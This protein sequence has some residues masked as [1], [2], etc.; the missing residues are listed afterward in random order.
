MLLHDLIL[1]RADTDGV[2]PALKKGDATI[3]YASACDGIRRVAAG[4]ANAGLR[5]GE[6]VAV[7]LN[8]R[9]EAVLSYFGATC[10]GGV[11]V[12]VNPSLKPAQVAHILRDCD[13][14]SLVTTS[15]QAAGLSEVLAGC[16]KLRD[17]ILLDETAP[18]PSLPPHVQALSWEALI[19]AA[20]GEPVR[21]IDTDMAAILYTSGSTG[22]PKGVVL[23]HR[24]LIV[25]GQSVSQYLANGP[26]D[27]I[28]SALPL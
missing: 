3:D 22:R 10:A 27:R 25:G 9:I 4:L 11:F 8:K 13:V 5:P 6:R 20:P 21:R 17:L 19:D 1:S 16:P 14:V 18:A 24:N 28:L 7:Y 2:R 26:H 12:P 23:S 15:A